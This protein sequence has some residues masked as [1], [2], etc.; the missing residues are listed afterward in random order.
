MQYQKEQVR[1]DIVRAATDEFYRHGYHKA[2]LRR[3]CAQAGI[4][5]G[6]LYRYFDSRDSLFD[7]VVGKLYADIM[8]LVKDRIFDND[9]GYDLKAIAYELYGYFVNNYGQEKKKILILLQGSEGSRYEKA[10]KSICT[11]MEKRIHDEYFSS[12]EGS[13]IDF[14]CGVL[15]NT[16][17]QGAIRILNMS[18]CPEMSAKLLHDLLI[19]VFD[20]VQSRLDSIKGRVIGDLTGADQIKE[21]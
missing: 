15:A 8:Y 11:M 12:I 2:S 7:E 10:A 20:D 5:V 6:N 19:I 4:S 3:I 14:A 1:R 17:L 16:F 13:E 9:S 21:A 18:D